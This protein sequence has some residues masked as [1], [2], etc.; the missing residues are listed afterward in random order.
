MP[1][2]LPVPFGQFYV[3]CGI[4]YVG[5]LPR[6][7]TDIWLQVQR[8]IQKN[9]GM[10]SIRLGIEIAVAVFGS[11]CYRKYWDGAVISRQPL[12]TRIYLHIYAVHFVVI[13][14]LTP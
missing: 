6:R 14:L 5:H 9:S 11:S 7:E 13:Y 1:R 3:G 12:F 8:N 4:R 10:L 2:R